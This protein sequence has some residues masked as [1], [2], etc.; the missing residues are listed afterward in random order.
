MR[1]A[2]RVGSSS[3]GCRAVALCFARRR[4]LLAPLDRLGETAAR[5]YRAGITG[6]LV[7]VVVGSLANDS[8]PRLFL[9]GAP[10]ILF[11]FLYARGAPA[12]SDR[13]PEG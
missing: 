8:G 12:G 11:A 10:F 6:A 5:A 13:S 4:A 9:V 7:A 3:E 1:R 2:L